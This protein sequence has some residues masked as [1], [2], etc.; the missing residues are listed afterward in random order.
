MLSYL[1]DILIYGLKSRGLRMIANSYIVLLSSTTQFGESI[2]NVT[3]L[4]F[5]N[6]LSPKFILKENMCLKASIV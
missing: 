3:F 2:S 4:M 5:T 1:G 6:S